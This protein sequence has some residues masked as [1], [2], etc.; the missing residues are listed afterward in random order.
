MMSE[1]RAGKR[2]ATLSACCG[3]HFVHDG[4]SDVIYFLL[5]LWQLEF[6]L[7]L[8]VVGIIKSLFSTALAL[9][10]IPAGILAEKLG[11]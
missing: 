2:K 11:A 7:T 8:A 3:A 9:G 6:G 1:R 10:Q 4:F 5:P